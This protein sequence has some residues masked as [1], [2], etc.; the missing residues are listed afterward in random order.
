M[1]YDPS[2]TSEKTRPWSRANA[3]PQ[4]PA[5]SYPMQEKP[6]SQSK[7]ARAWLRQ[8]MFSSPGSPPA[9]VMT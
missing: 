3:A 9:A 5:I 6:Y 2:P 4:A 7:E 8:L 1:R